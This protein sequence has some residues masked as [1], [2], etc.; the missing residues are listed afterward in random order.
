MNEKRQT[1]ENLG[2]GST[3]LARQG[4]VPGRPAT[5][6]EPESEGAAGRGR[7][8]W[9]GH[10]SLREWAAGSPAG[11]APARSPSTGSRKGA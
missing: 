5:A 10:G 4:S 9:R 1:A 3:R 8:R 11:E 6:P 2:D 7:G